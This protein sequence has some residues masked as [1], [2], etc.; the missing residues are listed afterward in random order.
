MNFL[1]VNDDGV[2]AEGI[3]ILVKELLT[4]AEKIVVVAPKVE[5]SANSHALTI[6]NGLTVEKCEDIYKGVDTY[7]L[8]GTPSDCVVFALNQLKLDIDIVVSGI[9]RGYNVGDDIIYSGTVAAALEGLMKNKK[10]IAFSCKYDSFEG[11]KY[12]GDVFKY[13]EE[14]D[15]LKENVVWN[16]NIP[17]ISRG[18][19]I[20]HQAKSTYQSKYE[21]RE[22]G[23]YYSLCDKTKE[24][25]DEPN[26]DIQ[27]I[28]KGYISISPLTFNMTSQ[29]IY[30]KYHK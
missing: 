21:I 7:A 5:M 29:N 1:V 18:I 9:N 6:K 14:N 24:L 28:K 16:V 12:I 11:S 15:M 8:A 17:A 10:A 2:N 13:L 27:T 20:T 19:K 22:D 23:C 26:G 25:L 3:K 30:N 4:F